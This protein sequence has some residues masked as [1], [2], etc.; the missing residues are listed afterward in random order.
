M[1]NKRSDAM[2]KTNWLALMLISALLPGQAFA[3][4]PN[5][6]DDEITMEVIEDLQ[7]DVSQIQLPTA[8]SDVAQENAAYG[9]ETA[10]A[11]REDGRAFG[12]SM[13]E[14]RGAQGGD[15]ASEA[16]QSAADAATDARQNAADVAADARENQNRGNGRP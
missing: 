7:G 14:M 11:A 6:E 1:I 4:E 10:N 15:I 8:A 3:D 2:S 9:L 12:Q 16:R 13:A 5:G